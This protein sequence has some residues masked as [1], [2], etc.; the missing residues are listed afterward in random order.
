MTKKP[1]FIHVLSPAAF[2]SKLLTT[3][4]PL[5]TKVPNFP[6]GRTVVMVT[7]NLFCYEN[8]SKLEYQ[9][10]CQ[11]NVYSNFGLSIIFVSSER[12]VSKPPAKMT[13]FISNLFMNNTKI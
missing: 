1:P 9:H 7:K 11:N 4:F 10:W 3:S 5:T 13:T 12:Q 2:A 6:V 8:Q